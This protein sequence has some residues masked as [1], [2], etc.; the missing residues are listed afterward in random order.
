MGAGAN[1]QKRK[2]FSVLDQIRGVLCL[3]VVFWHLAHAFKWGPLGSSLPVGVDVFFVLSG[4]VVAEAYLERLR[5]G[6]IT[7]G[8]LLI[9]RVI[10]FYPLMLIG[11]GLGALFIL[12][13]VVSG[14]RDLLSILAQTPQFFFLPVAPSTSIYLF[15]LDPPAWS[16]AAEMFVNVAFVFLATRMGGRAL[17]AV[18]VAGGIGLAACAFAYGGLNAGWGWENWPALFARVIFGFTI[19]M[20]VHRLYTSGVRAPVLPGLFLTSLVAAILIF[21]YVKGPEQWAVE[22]GLAL[23]MAPLAVWF[24]ASAN[25]GAFGAWL[26]RVSGRLSFSIYVIH[27]PLLALIVSF[28]RKFLH[29][30]GQNRYIEALVVMGVCIAAA[31]AADVWWDRPLNKFLTKIFLAP[32][33]ARTVDAVTPAR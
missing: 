28:D 13:D 7:P 20:L 18:T 3:F 17:T 12:G 2:T 6:K 21:V 30:L 22:A 11:L 15:P 27:Y 25:T 1:A 9:V 24:G 4:F 31:W 29:F 16:L 8:R 26:G 19:G 14:D 32:R 5:L 10:R 33:P 23:V